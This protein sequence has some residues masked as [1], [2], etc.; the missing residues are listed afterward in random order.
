MRRVY[1]SFD[2]VPPPDA[3]A[4]AGHGNLD[5]WCVRSLEETARIINECHKG[6]RPV[7]PKEVAK[8]QRS[9][10]RKLAIAL[11]AH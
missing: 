1:Q 3:F 8:I 10:F 11:E 2:R 5:A 6:D 7:T 9:A 4:G